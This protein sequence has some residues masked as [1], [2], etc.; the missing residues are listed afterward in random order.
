M[1]GHTGLLHGR[2]D[3]GLGG[4]EHVEH[5]SEPLVAAEPKAS[6]LVGQH[7]VVVVTLVLGSLLFV[8]LFLGGRVLND[9]R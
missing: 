2:D 8:G 6:H 9:R 3:D 1:I 7:F 4:E 5:G